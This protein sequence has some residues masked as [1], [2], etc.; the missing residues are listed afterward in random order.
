M[1]CCVLCV[2]GCKCFYALFGFFH[3]IFTLKSFHFLIALA[4]E[5]IPCGRGRIFPIFFCQKLFS[6]A[7]TPKHMIHVHTPQQ[8]SPAYLCNLSLIKNIFGDA[9]N[10]VIF[11]QSMWAI[12]RCFIRLQSNT[13]PVFYCFELCLELARDVRVVFAMR[14]K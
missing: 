11:H 9:T 1:C 12:S 10:L 8:K 13:S 2:C 14:S 5:A 6:Q 4:L 7:L 3:S